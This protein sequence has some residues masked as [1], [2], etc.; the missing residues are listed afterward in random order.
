MKA[1]GAPD[2]HRHA[3][4]L[5]LWVVG[6]VPKLPKTSNNLGNVLRNQFFGNL[7]L[8]DGAFPGKHVVELVDSVLRRISLR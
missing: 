2:A 1:E 6:Y 7:A 5:G 3:L 8:K 4:S